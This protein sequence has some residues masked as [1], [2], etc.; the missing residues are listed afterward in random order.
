[1]CVKDVHTKISGLYVTCL[2]QYMTNIKKDY[3][4]TEASLA[5]KYSFIKLK[6]SAV[7]KPMKINGQ[8]VNSNEYSHHTNQH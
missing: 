7:F 2:F 6:L 4:G 1:M 3:P 8:K 5:E